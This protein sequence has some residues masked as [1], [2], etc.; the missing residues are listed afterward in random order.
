MPIGHH[1]GGK[2]DAALWSRRLS[3]RVDLGIA[4]GQQRSN[5]FRNYGCKALLQYH[6]KE[7]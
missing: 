5:Q 3:K 4:P 7:N 1:P 6:E 2:D